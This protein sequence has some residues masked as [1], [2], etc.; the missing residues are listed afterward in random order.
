MTDKSGLQEAVDNANAIDETQ[1]T[2][3]SAADLQDAIDAA[4]A[5]LDDP[6]ATPADV[7]AAEQALQDAVDNLV[8][9][10]SELQAAVDAANALDKTGYTPDSVNALQDAID[11]AQARCDGR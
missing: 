11:A 5:V 4:Q 1:Y 2:P 3:D 9:D 10:K 7:A 6:D 8:V